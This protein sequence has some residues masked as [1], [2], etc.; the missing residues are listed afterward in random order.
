M[1]MTLDFTKIKWAGEDCILITEREHSQKPILILAKEKI[2]R[3]YKQILDNTQD[4]QGVGN[5]GSKS[6]SLQ[7]SDF[8]DLANQPQPSAPKVK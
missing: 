1:R 4:N 6:S 7:T 3:E 2:I 5:C 8:I